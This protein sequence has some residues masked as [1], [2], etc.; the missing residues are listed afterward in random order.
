MSKKL[1]VGNWKMNPQTSDDA[2][3]IFASYKKISVKISKTV[4]IACPPF[5]YLPLVSLTKG[6]KKVLSGAQDMFFE[7]EGAYTGEISPR[8]L[9]NLGASHVIIGHSERRNKMGETDEIVSK[10]TIAASV[11]GLIPIICVGEATHDNDGAYL[12]FLRN[13]IKASLSGLPIAAAKKIIIAYEPIWAIGAAEAMK[14]EDIRETALFIKKVFAD[15]FGQEVA[16]N[17]PVL[18]GGSVNWRNAADILSIGQVDGFLVGRESV[19]VPGFIELAK[20]M[21]QV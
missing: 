10:K 6:Q 1:L 15:I 17:L 5:V 16:L 2:K 21:D 8:M 13:Q 20:A 3:R 7:S 19:N 11:A 14:P 9:K 4:L 18:Y 12:E